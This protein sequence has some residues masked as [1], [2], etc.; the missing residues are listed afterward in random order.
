MTFNHLYLSQN[1]RIFIWITVVSMLT[2]W[3]IA[4][5]EMSACSADMPGNLSCH[6]S[7]DNDDNGG[8]VDSP[9]KQKQ[10]RGHN[11]SL[12]L[13]GITASSIVIL[14]AKPAY[15]ESQLHALRRI[16]LE[17]PPTPPPEIS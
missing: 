1:C 10:K 13:L 2:T 15:H 8:A 3:Q 17:A 5:A 16:L 9:I 12:Y 7:Q 6:L 4:A 14:P 11:F